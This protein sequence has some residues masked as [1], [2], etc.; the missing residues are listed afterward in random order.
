MVLEEGLALLR[1]PG[2]KRRIAECLEAMVAVAGTRGW[3]RR[4]ARLWGAAEA[5]RENIGAPLPRNEWAF[6]EPYISAARI[7]L[8]EETWE[9]A[10]TEGRAMTP[11]E[12]I[13]YALS[14]EVPG[15]PASPAAD[16][17]LVG[18]RPNGLTRRE[19][20]VAA[21][22]ARGLTNRQI[23]EELFVSGRTVDHHVANIL[24][25]LELRSREQVAPT[26]D[27]TTT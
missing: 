21:L 22:V 14:K 17:L 25:K 7:R 27:R 10:C 3:V 5:L 24:K 19:R 20:E 13:G 9:A 4:S 2:D 23:A 1:E 12:A 15:P 6:L 26:I 11:E 16:R 18:G 8:G